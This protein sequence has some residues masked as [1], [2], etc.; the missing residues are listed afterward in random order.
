MKW[1][2]RYLK[3]TKP[4]YDD[5]LVFF[6]PHIREL[7]LSFDREMRERFKVH[8]KYHRYLNAAGWAY[9]YGRSYNCELLAVT[10]DS[11]CFYVLNVTVTDEESLQT[12]LAEAQKIYDSGFEGRYTAICAKRREDQIARTKQ[13]V[14]REKRQIQELTASVNPDKFNKFKWCKKI[15]RSDLLRLYQSEA[16]R[17]IDEE[18][19]DKVG[20]TFYTRCKQSKDTLPLL[21]QG[22]IICHHCGSVL[23]ASGYDSVT[24]CE[25]G[26]CYTYREYR[27]SFNTNNMPAHRAQPLFDTFI[28]KWPTCKDTN[29]KMILI[30]WLIHE[31]HVTFM[32]GER[33][34]SVCVNLIDGTTAQ[35]RDLLEMLAGH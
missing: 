8:N 13:R 32:S 2:D 1:K 4:T 16:K 26:Y 24:N 3:K 6:Q 15:S 20:F 17:L 7:F 27:R 12:A 28:D 19:L 18:L 33:G 34:R 30:D 31:C 5:L 10:I 21:N 35:L 9:G 23:K 11:D 25:C 22:Q 29:E 14:A